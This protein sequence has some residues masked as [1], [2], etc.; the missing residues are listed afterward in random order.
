[1]PASSDVGDKYNLYVGGSLT[2]FNSDITM[3]SRDDSVKKEID[4]EDDLGLDDDLQFGWLSGRWRLT[5]RHRVRF[6]YQPIRRSSGTTLV[7]DV[8]VGDNTIRAGA[9]ADSSVE[10]DIYDIDYLYSFHKT[11]QWENSVSAGLYWINNR[12]EIKADGVIVSDIDGSEELRSSFR[13]TQ[14]LSAPL[15][16]VGVESS[17]ELNSKVRF[18][19]SA[20]YLDVEINDISG[21]VLTL[22]FR[23]DYYFNRHLGVGLSL[24]SFD[25][26][27]EQQGIVFINE[28]SWKSQGAQIYLALRY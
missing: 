13:A 1:M 6:I 11:T 12:T 18:H 14:T 15:P 16:L 19:G 24:T 4:F 20:R 2:T 25:L 7:S 17:Y 5:G 21:R 9:A 22:G 23:A 8:D 3:N 26:N 10:T 27:V 28:L